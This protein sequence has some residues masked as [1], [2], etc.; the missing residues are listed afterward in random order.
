M[1]GYKLLRVRK[2]KTLGSLFINRKQVLPMDTWLEA[3]DHPTKGFA[4][5]PGW[6]ITATPNAP[7]L[8]IK[9]RVWACVEFDGNIQELKRPER[10][11]GLWF[12][13]SRMKI[14][15]VLPA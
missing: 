14:V 2:N 4:H 11:G 13:A 12:L 15:K 10:Q 5:R 6:H 9:G 1:I 7:H 3:E 8:T